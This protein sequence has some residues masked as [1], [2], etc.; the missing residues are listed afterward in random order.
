MP[1]YKQRIYDPDCQ[2]P[3]CLRRATFKVFNTWNGFVGK[4]CGP[5]ADKAIARLNGD[6]RK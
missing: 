6:T 1:A 3:G 2:E 5:H 4:F